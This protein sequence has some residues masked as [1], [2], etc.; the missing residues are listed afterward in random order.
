MYLEYFVRVPREARL[1]NCRDARALLARLHAQ[2]EPA[3]QFDLRLLQ[4]EDG[5]QPRHVPTAIRIGS[6]AQS[7]MISAVGSEAVTCLLDNASKAGG[8]VARHFGVPLE[9]HYHQG[10]CE[11][12]IAARICSYQ[13]PS[14][15][16]SR[17]HF[18]RGQEGGTMRNIVTKRLFEHPALLERVKCMV[19]DGI[20]R[21]ANVCLLDVPPALLGD[22]VVHRL[23]P[24]LVKRGVYFVVGAVSFRAG[25][26]LVGPWYAG[27]L[28]SRGYGRIFPA[29]SNPSTAF[30]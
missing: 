12:H 27:H 25:W 3:A 5:G 11:V 2:A 18:D 30:R 29:R 4:L 22:V 14:L 15:V 6:R 20:Q 23:A 1:R 13:I 7:L 17:R 24:V 10:D 9:E 21:Q 28:Q 19:A 8:L 26:Q 16:L